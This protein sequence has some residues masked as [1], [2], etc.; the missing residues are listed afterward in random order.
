MNNRMLIFG[1][2]ACVSL[3]TFPIAHAQF[4]TVINVPPDA[5]PASIGSD[6]QLNFAAGG[7]DLPANFQ[8]GTS[9]DANN[10]EVNINSGTVG[11]M[12]NAGPTDGSGGDVTVNIHGGTLGTV[13]SYAGAEVLVSGGSLGVVTAFGGDIASTAGSTATFQFFGASNRGTADFNGGTAIGGSGFSGGFLSVFGST[14]VPE[15]NINGG[16]LMGID[17]FGDGSSRAT[18]NINGGQ[19]V[20]NLNGDAQSSL[21]FNMTGGEITGDIRL[22]SAF[23][24]TVRITGGSLQNLV[25]GSFSGGNSDLYPRVE[26]HG[27]S[28]ASVDMTLGLAFVTYHGTQFSVDG[29]DVTGT[30]TPGVP[31]DVGVIDTLSG[32]LAD[33]TAFSYDFPASSGSTSLVLVEAASAGDFDMDG[34][35]DGHDFLLWQRDPG[36]GSLSDWQANYGT[37]SV[38]NIASVPEPSGGMLLLLSAFG[39]I[40][41]RVRRGRRGRIC[42]L[43]FM[44]DEGNKP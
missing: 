1:I 31:V 8:A 26:I 14:H 25:T 24:S 11:D 6:T 39:L 17:Y 16:V 20:G 27:G 3:A 29:V 34:D 33:G 36:V 35:V 19:V 37:P 41:R 12:F 7:D 22:D 10:I 43:G 23:S 5:A 18:L 4:T 44:I 21:D 40:N 15:L 32:V 42:D 9:G 2:F 30:L 28:I 13:T 38:A